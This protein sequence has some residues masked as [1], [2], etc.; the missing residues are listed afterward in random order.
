MSRRRPRY[1]GRLRRP[2]DDRDEHGAHGADAAGIGSAAPDR[3]AT[4]SV[5]TRDSTKK[6][7]PYWRRRWTSRK[8]S[9]S[10]AAC[11]MRGCWSGR[12]GA[13]FPWSPTNCWR[14]ERPG[15]W[16]RSPTVWRVPLRSRKTMPSSPND[17]GSVLYGH[18]I[19]GTGG[20]TLA[21]VDTDLKALLATLDDGA[22]ARAVFVIPRPPRLFWRRCAAPAARR[23][24]RRSPRPA[25]RC[26]AC[27]C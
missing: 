5:H 14:A 11:G 23:R 22:T 18:G 3:V 16:R 20:S 17:P 27:R 26:W 25:A 9:R 8:R 4:G 6:P 7:G 10:C 19:T 1:A 24:I 13:R 15:R 12:S 21:N 2:A